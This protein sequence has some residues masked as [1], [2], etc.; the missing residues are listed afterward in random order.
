MSALGNRVFDFAP[1]EDVVPD[2]VTIEATIIAQDVK[3][4]EC[5]RGIGSW[6]QLKMK[7]GLGGGLAPI[8][9]NH[10]LLC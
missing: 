1:T 8:W 5:E 9:V 2:E 6:P 4:R 3:N 10:D 7:V